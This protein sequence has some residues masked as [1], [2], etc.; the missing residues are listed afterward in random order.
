MRT[1]NSNTAVF[2]LNRIKELSRKLVDSSPGIMER[3]EM[4]EEW[5]NLTNPVNM[6]VLINYLENGSS[7]SYSLPDSIKLTD[8]VELRLHGKGL[9][10]VI[11]VGDIELFDNEITLSKMKSQ[12][13]HVFSPDGSLHYG[14]IKLVELS[15][16]RVP[17]PQSSNVI[18]SDEIP[19]S[20]YSTYKVSEP[21]P[22]YIFEV[23][24]SSG[25]LDNVIDVIKSNNYNTNTSL[26]N[27]LV[28][29]R[30]CM[31]RDH[32]TRLNTIINGSQLRGM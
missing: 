14:I 32:Y 27:L 1:F 17:V 21:L 29:L 28:L 19:T 15:C 5:D 20:I 13:L 11:K 31:E 12:M 10:E 9:D 24:R 23:V 25:P 7:K 30:V 16:I 3:L 2:Q 6:N 4:Q 22:D 18:D 26:R 8:C